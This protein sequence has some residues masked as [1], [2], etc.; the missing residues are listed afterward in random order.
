MVEGDE[1]FQACLHIFVETFQKGK[2]NGVLNLRGFY[3]VV[4]GVVAEFWSSLK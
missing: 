4:D 1:A 2:T 3:L